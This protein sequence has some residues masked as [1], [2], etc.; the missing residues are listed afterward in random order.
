MIAWHKKITEKQMKMYGI[1][2]YQ[3]LWFSWIKGLIMGL[4][5]YH[6]FIK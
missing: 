3:G 6:F 4:L 2:N 5:V 1:S